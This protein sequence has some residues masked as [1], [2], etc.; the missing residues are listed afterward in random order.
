M[1]F[2]KS[3]RASVVAIAVA[4]ALAA[5]SQGQ[6]QSATEAL[7]SPA[8]AAVP[9]ANERGLPDFTALVDAQGKAV[10]NISTTGVMKTGLD[11]SPDDAIPEPF[12]D[13]FRDFGARPGLREAP[14]H[15]IGSGFIITPD[16]YILTN[17][18]VVS[19]ANELTV[20]L[21]DRRELKAKVIGFDKRSDV[22]LIKVDAKDL[23]TVR[24][25][26]PSRLKVGEWVAAIGSPF[27]FEN[28]V[29]AGIVS[30][31]ARAMPGDGYV[32]FIQ[33]DVPI[34]PGNS[35]GPLFNMAGEVIG[36]N[37]QIY[38]HNGGY[39]GVS[40]AIPIDVA[41]KVESQL[42]KTGKVTRGYLGIGIQEVDQKL[43]QSFGLD[44]PRG[45]LI[46]AVSDGGAGAKAGLKA[47]DIVTAVNGQPISATSDLQRAIADAAPGSS[48]RLTLWRDRHE[49]SVQATVGEA[50]VDRNALASLGNKPEGRLGVT[51]RAL[52]RDEARN[53][54]VQGGLVVEDATGPAQRAGLQPGDVILS[55]NQHEVGTAADLRQ[56]V[57]RADKSIT[58]LIARNGGRLFVPVDLG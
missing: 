5:C 44:Q 2:S 49:Q 38:S 34:N 10:V 43:A 46:S 33:T 57:D 6:I 4:A 32:P 30:A 15:G 7:H 36:I 50:Q 25:G 56:Q 29:T 17:A 16:G 54:A 40:F 21:V 48:V 27:G 58:L 52:T 53:I 24:I 3:L 47:G 28:T 8:H 35:G 20:K 11:T 18:H 26:D 1:K 45:A 42:A 55:A 39:M 19:G 9:A 12:R 23:P 31:K 51:V 41:M 13:F 22:A 37:S 14:V